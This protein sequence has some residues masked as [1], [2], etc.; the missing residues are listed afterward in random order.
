[1]I[2]RLPE[3]IS[4]LEGRSP[5]ERDSYMVPVF[6]ALGWIEKIAKDDSRQR[7]F[8]L[9][10]LVAELTRNGLPKKI[11]TEVAG[12]IVHGLERQGK[13]L[14][15]KRGMLDASP[16]FSTKRKVD[17]DRGSYSRERHL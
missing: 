10:E 13:I 3:G 15:T 8:W 2:F 6:K 9:N 4:L 16:I 14:W 11:S 12:K 17:D 1:M 7:Q 5:E